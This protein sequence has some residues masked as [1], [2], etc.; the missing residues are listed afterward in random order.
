MTRQTTSELDQQQAQAL[1]KSFGQRIKKLRKERSWTQKDLAS[2][3]DV[4]FSVLNKYESGINVP[5]IEKLIALADALQTSVDYLL[6][7][8]HA[9]NNPVYNNRLLERLQVI[10]H[11]SPD[12]QETALTVLDALILKHEVSGRVSRF[13]S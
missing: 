11:F 9:D 6:T 13:E 12:E 1:R 10:Q 8:S 4:P 5:P 7:G 3:L 2:K